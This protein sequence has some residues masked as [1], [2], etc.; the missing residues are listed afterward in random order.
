MKNYPFLFVFIVV[1]LG[2]PTIFAQEIDYNLDKHKMLIENKGQWDDQIFFQSKFPGGNLWVQQHKLLFHLQDYSA[3]RAA[4]ANFSEVIP[5][6]DQF[7]QTVVHANF[8]GSNEITV[9][10]KE[11]PSIHYY[12]YFLGN[13]PA[14]WAS[15]VHSY[16]KAKL[17]NLYD[18]ID[19][20]IIQTANE[21]KYE[22]HVAPNANPNSI[23]IEYV[24]QKSLKIDK[25]GNLTIA[26]DLG[27]I[28]EKKPYVYQIIN[29]RIIEIASQF[30]LKNGVVYF[31]LGKYNPT[32][33]LIIDPVLVFATYSGSVT[34]NFGMSGTYG[35]DGT[36][37]SAG[38]VYGNTYP[39]PF[40]GA[41]DIS[42]S[43]TTI[44][45]GIGTTD[46][47][48]S[49][50]NET[51]SQ[52][53]WTNFLGGA[54][55]NV[56]TETPQSMICDPFNNLYLY[57]TTSSTDFPVLATAYQSTHHLGTPGLQIANNGVSFNASGTDIYVS[58]L[59]AD[60]TSLLGS[61]FV[62]GSGNDGV[63][64]NI[65]GG[66]YTFASSYDS[67]STNYGDQFRGEIM[68][69]NAGNCIVGT[70]TRSTDFPTSNP[71][72]GVNAGML[73]GVVFRL[74]NDLTALQFSTYFGGAN[75]D[76]IYSVKVD[77]NSNIVF[78][79]GTSSLNLPGTAGKYQPTYQGGISDGFVGKLNASGTVLQGATYLGT[80]NYDQAFFVEINR[81][82]KIFVTGQSKGGTFPVMNSA[83]SIPN[84]NN[85]IAKLDENLLG[86]EKST[87]YGVSASNL[88]L[89]PS[90][91]LVDR[92]GEI[93][94]SGWGS[95]LLTG[96]PM[97]GFPVTAN[98][99]GSNSTSVDFHLFVLDRNFSS[100]NYGAYIGG[101][102][103]PEHV[104]G[105]TSRFDRN[106]VVYQSVCGGCWGNSDF[107]TTSGAWSQLNLCTTANTGGQAGCNNVLFKFDFQT[108]TVADFTISDTAICLNEPITLTNNSS[109]SPYDSYY[110]DL[111]NGDTSYAYNPTLTFT[112]PGNYVIYLIVTDSVCDRSDTTQVT[113][114]I[115]P[116][117][118]LSVTNDTIVCTASSFDLL[119]NS[120]GSTNSFVWSSSI[121]FLDTLNS[122]P[123][124]SMITVSP[125][126]SQTYYVK[127][128]NENCSRID[129]VQ[130][131]ILSNSILLADT[132][133]YCE[134]ETKDIIVTE[135]LPA[136]N[137]QYQWSPTSIIIGP[138]NSSTVSTNTMIS[139]YLFVTVN[140]G[141]GC[142]FTDSIWL[143][144]HNI[145]TISV[146]ASAN[147][148]A[149]PVGGISVLTATPPGASYSWTPT[150]GLSNPLSQITEA[151]VNQDTE[152]T[153][154]VT[155][156]ICTNT[157]K[158]K[159]TVF[160]YSCAD[161]YIFVPNAFSPNADQEN[162]V[163]FVRSQIL[164]QILFRVFNRWGELVFETTDIS[165]GWDGTF[166]GKLMDPD[167]Y[168]Y[169][170]KAVCIDG[171]ENIIKGN[172]TLLR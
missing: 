103:S 8:L 157:A 158:T 129:S 86:I 101:N 85:F 147:P 146:G 81:V 31:D 115:E 43:F 144:V 130:I 12:N 98:P 165:K 137:F 24:G 167:V 151:V 80:S 76:A 54:N 60:G 15:K 132:V 164:D 30:K 29:G 17:K 121:S 4:H 64:Y 36:A 105:G 114:S 111:G 117:L 16:H 41:Y 159:V 163:L 102:T 38:T 95:N 154:V 152:F 122:A 1:L 99:F 100:M 136:L 34:D 75:N 125:L 138:T 108:Q 32:K 156:G 97:P 2:H 73:D 78:S 25:K 126:G 74:S 65:S 19:L 94:V 70:C 77:S 170:L 84:S 89:S 128:E 72:Q 109:T 14:K 57:G 171:Q 123:M 127:I 149:V 35:Y 116:E 52:M 91:F 150:T 168:D 68:L 45:N 37:Y 135:L 155:D 160:E 145:A 96:A 18:G 49:K 92:C 61:T 124:D 62:G 53:I 48:I 113:I 27:R 139:Q 59:S 50:Y 67:L 161:P 71:I 107:P 10:E 119:A 172:V 106:G 26:T 90:A 42:T 162:D 47:Y 21:T 56:G 7:K 141:F 112:S 110:W 148:T 63:N 131:L 51:G 39:V 55:P 142:V 20:Q 93:Y 79:G 82:N 120:F 83:Y 88:M 133:G 153:V 9:V 169:Y 11:L 3:Y 33:E 23:R 22:F 104:D 166:N 143:D 5:N 134:G 44:Y 28:V 40:S 118:V 58:K 13:D 6:S 87:V 69:D 66:N 46:V 140:A